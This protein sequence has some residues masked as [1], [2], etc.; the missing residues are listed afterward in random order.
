MLLVEDEVLT[1]KTF[2]HPV[3]SQAPR[4]FIPAITHR[5]L[6]IDILSSANAHSAHP[7]SYCHY[8]LVILL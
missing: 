3:D 6:S 5:F 1:A 2:G 7:T 8:L 4:S